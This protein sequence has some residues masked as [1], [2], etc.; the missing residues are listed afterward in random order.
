[1][2]RSAGRP[3]RHD[4]QAGRDVGSDACGRSKGRT[5]KTFGSGLRYRNFSDPGLRFFYH[6]FSNSL[7]LVIEGEEEV[8]RSDLQDNQ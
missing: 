1:M 3:P 6:K 5:Q 2:C 7:L 4:P 8:P